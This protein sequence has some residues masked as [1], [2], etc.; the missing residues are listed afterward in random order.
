MSNQQVRTAKN[1][2][3][4][5]RIVGK[6]KGCYVWECQCSCGQKC[7]VESRHLNNR[8]K[9]SCGC[10]QREARSRLGKKYGKMNSQLHRQPLADRFS[11]HVNKD[12]PMP[13]K[14]IGFGNC[15][16]WEGGADTNGRAQMGGIEGK[17]KRAA[18][19]AVAI[20]ECLVHRSE[21]V[22]FHC[23]PVAQMDRAAVS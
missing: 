18:H 23:G 11:N 22:C 12:G 20:V 10:L 16:I 4:A 17:T 19:I 1:L 21:L 6:Q 7:A 13:T 9:K 14:C 3:R 5:L 8:N 15:W 2:Q